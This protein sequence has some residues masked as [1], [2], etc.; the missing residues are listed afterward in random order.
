MQWCGLFRRHVYR[1]SPLL[2]S[3]QVGRLTFKNQLSMSGR[4]L[5]SPDGPL[6]WIDCEMTGLD[7]RTDKILEIAVLQS[8]E[9]PTHI[10]NADSLQVIIT[11]GNLEPVHGGVQYVIRT[12]QAVLDGY[13]ITSRTAFDAV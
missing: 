1:R 10:T 11:D 6:V 3:Y 12:D 4:T 5:K 8:I 13:A 9:R 7:P 2:S